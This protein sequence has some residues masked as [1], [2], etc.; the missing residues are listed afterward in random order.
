MALVNDMK[1]QTN[2]KAKQEYQLYN[3]YSTYSNMPNRSTICILIYYFRKK[4]PS[5]LFSHK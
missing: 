2:L 1:E 5:A 3:I 4:N